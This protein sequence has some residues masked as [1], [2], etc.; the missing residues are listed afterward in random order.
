MR[1]LSLR[2]VSL[3]VGDDKIAEKDLV[4]TRLTRLSLA[5]GFPVFQFEVLENPDEACEGA[6]S[7]FIDKAVDIPIV[8]QREIRM[9]RNVHETIEIHQLQHTDQVVDVPVVL[10]AQVPQ[11]R[12]VAETAEIPQL[13]LGEKIVAIP[14][15]RTVQGPRTSESLSGEITVAGKMDHETWSY[16]GLQDRLLH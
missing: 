16:A 2:R 10:V 11:V 13:L 15:A 3:I 8:A 12:I 4:V 9:N 7:Q 1:C 14:E 5:L 6:I